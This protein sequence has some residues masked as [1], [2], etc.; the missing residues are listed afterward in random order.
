VPQRLFIENVRLGLLFRTLQ[1]LLFVT[2]LAY[3][4]PEK[5]WLQKV[6][7][8]AYGT[9]FT[10]HRKRRNAGPVEAAYCHDIQQYWFSNSSQQLEPSGC[11]RSGS[12]HAQ[13]VQSHCSEETA[14]FIPTFVE[15]RV[16]TVALGG[17]ECGQSVQMHC[18]GNSWLRHSQSS[19]TSSAT[20]QREATT[21]C[22]CMENRDFRLESVEHQQVILFHGYQA[23][24]SSTSQRWTETETIENR[25]KRSVIEVK[26]Q[27]TQTRHENTDGIMTVV[28]GH[29][30]GECRLGGRHK[31][32]PEDSGRGIDGT[33]KEWL[34]CA[35]IGHETAD[36][37]LTDH[38]LQHGV[39]LHVRLRYDSDHNE[40]SHAGV[41]CTLTVEVLPRTA[42][43]EELVDALPLQTNSVTAGNT[44]T[45]HHVLA[46]AISMHHGVLFTMSASGTIRK[47]GLVQCVELI[48]QLAVLFTFP[49]KMTNVLAL[50][51]LGLISEIYRRARRTRLRIRTALQ[52]S[53]AKIL[54]AENSFRGLTGSL[55]EGHARIPMRKRDVL[56][57]L[58]EVF[59]TPDG[60]P[61]EVDE[62]ALED[63]AKICVQRFG[64]NQDGLERMTCRDFVQYCTAQDV[65]DV[66][67]MARFFAHTRKPSLLSWLFDPSSYE[68]RHG[69]GRWK[70]DF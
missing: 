21:L 25:G 27:G 66:R 26:L 70:G 3:C 14:I 5:V 45:G 20:A 15:E 34:S 23:H 42:P 52:Q 47:F 18:K 39:A 32:L 65:V 4:V 62:K 16:E 43:T 49:R 64:Q 7:P 38:A 8:T 30:G 67:C 68:E 22:S 31:W 61:S 9:R 46:A 12:L 51:G 6:T 29:D 11:G 59:Q 37:T 17:P 40:L 69:K 57:H 63:L 54:L 60:E 48:V 2:V 19:G 10:T 1:V 41:L 35:G 53:V 56:H 24:A 36:H 55:W 28:V 58:K 33:L 44:G 13:A 50:Y